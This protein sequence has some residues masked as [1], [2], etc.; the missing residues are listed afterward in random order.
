ML[1][2]D[3]PHL[4]HVYTAMIVILLL[5][6]ESD[7]DSDCSSLPYAQTTNCPSSL[8]DGSAMNAL[9]RRI[10][11]ANAMRSQSLI[12]EVH[13][14]REGGAGNGFSAS[15]HLAYSITSRGGKTTAGLG[16]IPEA[17]SE[18]RPC[19]AAGGTHGTRVELCRLAI[20]QL[21]RPQRCQ[22]HRT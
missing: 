1:P 22:H 3:I 11:E 12:L 18:L 20:R 13:R 8:E 6:S 4:L 21:A 7:T 17:A 16:R 19:K 10:R 14:D 9:L 2:I 5:V 15:F